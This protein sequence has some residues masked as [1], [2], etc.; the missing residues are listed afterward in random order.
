[1]KKSL[2]ELRA[3]KASLEGTMRSVFEGAKEQSRDFNEAETERFDEAAERLDVVKAEIA[4]SE[5]RIEA[6]RGLVEGGSTEAGHPGADP[7][8]YEGRN[9]SGTRGNTVRDQAMR[10]V[11]RGL[12]ANELPDYAA[13]RI[14]T[15]MRTGDDADLTARWAL[16]A[17]SPEYRTAF[18]KVAADPARGHL[19]WTA[20][21]Q[22]A[23]QD[24][25]QVSRALQIDTGTGH[26]ALP[27]SLDP[28]V[29]L[30]N[31]G[32][33]N[34]LRQVARVVQITGSEYRGITSAGVTAEWLPE[35]QE[36]ADASPTLGQPV[37]KAEKGAAFVPFSYEFQQDSLGFLE[38]LRG[39]LVDGADQLQA[40]A[41]ML[42]SGTNEPK[43]LITALVA[44]GGSVIVSG[45]GEAL[46]A[47]DFYAVQNALGP[48][49]LGNAQWVMNLSTINGARQMETTNGSVKFPSLDLNP[50]TLLGRRVNEASFVDG[51][52]NPAATES[53]YVAAYGDFH[54]GFTIVDRIGTTIHLISDLFGAAR[55][56]TGERGAFMTFR[57][58]SDV[59]NTSALKLLRYNTTA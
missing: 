51:V 43:G 36:A 59:V 31:A 41:F 33:S 23:Y 58:G 27:I 8:A 24:V 42:G 44:A 32:S 22:R 37:I 49:Y 20:S 2:E 29:H 15:L 10:Q 9:L 53:N 6:M 57:T 48:R 14:E 56:P 18:A 13:E 4:Q 45:T 26:F 54:A 7:N 30:T 21:E 47:N 1:M 3:E 16:T 55:R 11:E 52:I 5:R 35:S 19:L 40:Q 50:P 34:P 28:V 38:E 12:K 46:N 39:L 17:G 25:H